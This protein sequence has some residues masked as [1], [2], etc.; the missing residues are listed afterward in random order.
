MTEEALLSL[1]FIGT[2]MGGGNRWFYMKQIGATTLISTIGDSDTLSWGVWVGIHMDVAKY[3]ENVTELTQLITLL[4][5]FELR[6]FIN[7]YTNS[8]EP[9]MEEEVG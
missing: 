7:P 3:T 9:T 8:D 6:D 2:D 4:D 1:N 5:G